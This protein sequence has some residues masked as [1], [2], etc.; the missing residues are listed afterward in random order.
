MPDG[1][2]DAGAEVGGH[3]VTISVAGSKGA[4]QASHTGANGGAVGSAID[5]IS[6]IKSSGT[7]ASLLGGQVN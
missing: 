3:E 5:G 2:D 1:Q 4:N 7:P 6:Y